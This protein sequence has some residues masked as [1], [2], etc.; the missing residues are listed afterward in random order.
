MKTKESYFFAAIISLFFFLNNSY[1]ANVLLLGDEGS[2]TEVQQALEI[3]GHNVIYGGLYWE[4]NGS[5]P[6]PVNFDLILYLGGVVYDDTLQESAAMAINTFVE[7]GGVLVLTEWIAYEGNGKHPIICDLMPVYSPDGNYDEDD[8]WTVQDKGHPLTQNV[9]DSWYVTAAGWSNVLAK[10]G[11]I[12][13]I[14]GTDDNPLLSYKKVNDGTVLHIN[15]DMAY[16]GEP[17]DANVLKLIVN[18]ADYANNGE[19]ANPTK[20]VSIPTMNEWGMIILMTLLGF[21]G[22][23]CNLKGKQ[24]NQR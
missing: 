4:W 6:N 14:T 10:Q 21:V 20:I 22:A 13:L 9:P 17:I 2:E 16:S 8:T 7:N 18:A 23:L 12:V 19:A 24:G 11:T 15:H 1:A 3:A 5:D